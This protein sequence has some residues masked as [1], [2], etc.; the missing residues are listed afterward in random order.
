MDEKNPCI[1]ADPSGDNWP[2]VEEV[3]EELK[4]ISQKKCRKERVNFELNKISTKKFRDGETKPKIE[5]N[6]RKRN[7]YFI[8][9]PCEIPSAWAFD[10]SLVN[11][12]LKSSS[13]N[14]VINV[15]L[16]LPF[17]RQDRKD[18]SRVP[19]SAKVVAETLQRD[20][21]R[22]LTLD[23]HNP[24]IGGFYNI[25]FD[26]LES[27]PV[28]I[29]YLKENFPRI[30]KNLVVASPDVGGGKRVELVQGHLR[31]YGVEV[32]IGY[33]KR[34]LNGDVERLEILGE[35][36]GKKVILYDDICDSGGTLCKASKALR[37][38]GAS[39]IYGYCTHGLF[40]EGIEKVVNNFDLF[41][42]GNT[43][44]QKEHPKLKVIS[45]APLFAEAIY[46]TETGD[47]LS[48]LF[49]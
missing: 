49:K 6:V 17:S 38:K 23:V 14:E 41:F 8:P 46:R 7:C 28:T 43:R 16:Y 47:S 40:T 29:K 39:E 34:G 13:A 31:E 26:N 2:F 24:A 37:E 35:V 21:D 1:V 20:A 22:I 3:Y 25:A 4:K 42:V 5:S 27:Y 10:T 18:E 32:A 45:F 44:K 19:I 11:S 12:A 33:K 15:I 9:K 36:E 48:E 30:F